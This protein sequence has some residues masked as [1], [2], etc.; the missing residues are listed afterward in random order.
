MPSTG[1]LVTTARF[2]GVRYVFKTSTIGESNSA[3]HTN[4]TVTPLL[5]FKP[6]TFRETGQC[7]L[8]GTVGGQPKAAHEPSQRPDV[9]FDRR[10]A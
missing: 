7:V 5:D 3:G 2:S 1:K 8:G 6:Q 10:I 4:C 9:R